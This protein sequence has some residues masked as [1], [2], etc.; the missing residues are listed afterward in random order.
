[1]NKNHIQGRRGGRAGTT[2]RSPV[3]DRGGKC[4]GCAEKQRALT[5][6][7]PAAATPWEVSR[8]RSSERQAGGWGQPV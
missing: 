2:Q 1:M 4:G 5:W 3:L 6:G 8:D 7:D